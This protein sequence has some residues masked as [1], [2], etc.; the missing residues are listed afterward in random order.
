MHEHNFTKIFTTANFIYWSQNSRNGSFLHYAICIQNIQQSANEAV[1]NIRRLLLV[2]CYMTARRVPSFVLVCK[3][4]SFKVHTMSILKK[5][6]CVY[7]ILICN[8]SKKRKLVYILQ[9]YHVCHRW[10]TA[11]TTLHPGKVSSQKTVLCQFLQVFLL[12]PFV[13][14]YWLS[15][16]CS[17]GEVN[18]LYDALWPH[19]MNIRSF[20]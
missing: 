11:F 3:T 17:E 13:S 7:N 5:T 10:E 12:T 15:N 14:H 6:F 4:D 2:S 8:R 16:Y 1:Y 9:L 20:Q 19:T 18:I